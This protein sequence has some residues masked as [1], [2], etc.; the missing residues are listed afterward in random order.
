MCGDGGDE[1]V[2]PGLAV[3]EHSRLRV[4]IRSYGCSGLRSCSWGSLLLLRIPAGV[5]SERLDRLHPLQDGRQRLD[6]FAHFDC[7]GSTSALRGRSRR[8]GGIA[9][10]LRRL[11][12]ELVLLAHGFGFPAM[13]FY[14]DVHVVV[15]LQTAT[16][17]VAQSG[18]WGCS[19]LNVRRGG[20]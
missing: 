14:F 13:A 11:P 3:T 7:E 10:T 9:R 17:T 12:L 20:T 19:P 1:V 4:V 2:Q 16:V 8:L 18:R 5:S 15:P 6:R